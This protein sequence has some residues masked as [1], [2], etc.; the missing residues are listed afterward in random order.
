MVTVAVPVRNGGRYISEV[1]Q[2]VRA[3]EVNREIEL[4]VVDSGSTDGSP[5]IARDHGARVVEIPPH[6]FGHGR[7]RNLMM[8]LAAGEH[9]A[10]L[11]Q[12]A[13]PADER[14]LARLLDG[15]T[16]ADDVAL[17]CGPYVAR[18]DASLPVKREL[19]DFFAGFSPAGE[20]VVQRL[21]AGAASEPGYRRPVGPL[22]FFSDVNGCVARWAWEKVPYRDVAYAEDQLL[23]AE[24]LEAG[25]AKVFEPR[26]VVRHSHDY[27]AVEYFRRCFDE[28]RALREVFDHREPVAPR[29]V[30]GRI[31]AEVLADRRFARDCGARESG[32]LRALPASVRHHTVRALG[33]IAGSRADR[34]PRRLRGAISLEG[35][36]DFRTAPSGRVEQDV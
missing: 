19:H 13:T 6:E 30:L 7:T 5:A 32:P 20:P 12:D 22:T 9:V 21:L 2:A 4:L 25:M 29:R 23:A 28:W 35:R 33:S 11:T 1:L 24:M 8:R 15:F 18:A 10:F 14:W 27:S 26:A 36:D 3:Q 17:S 16:L 31:R 34:L